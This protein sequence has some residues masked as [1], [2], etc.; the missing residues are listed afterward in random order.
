MTIMG[1][2]LLFLGTVGFLIGE[3]NY[4]QALTTKE[5]NISIVMVFLSLIIVGVS[6]Y[7]IIN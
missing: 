2:I 7:L 6:V 4:H 3:S 1:F 5:I